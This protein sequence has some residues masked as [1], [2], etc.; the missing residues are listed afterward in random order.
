M[1]KDGCVNQKLNDRNPS[2]FIFH[3]GVITSNRHKGKLK[4]SQITSALSESTGFGRA[5]SNAHSNMLLFFERK[6]KERGGFLISIKNDN[7]I[8]KYFFLMIIKRKMGFWYHKQ[9][10]KLYTHTHY[11]VNTGILHLS[12]L[13][14]PEDVFVPERMREREI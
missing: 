6:K 1:R 7:F 4:T 5:F 14:L 13:F 12:A 8:I 3:K 2:V 9:N 10:S 11:T